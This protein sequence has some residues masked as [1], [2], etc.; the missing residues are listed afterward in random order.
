MLCC[1]ECYSFKESAIQKKYIYQTALFEL[2]DQNYLIKFTFC[3]CFCSLSFTFSLATVLTNQGY[4][5]IK[6]I[7][8]YY[9][10]IVL[11]CQYYILHRI[12]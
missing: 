2:L 8:F 1:V 6:K 5:R 3:F 11:F 12:A 9:F 7:T 10:I 4:V